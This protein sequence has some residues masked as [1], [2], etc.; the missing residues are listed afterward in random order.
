[1]KKKTKAQLEQERKEKFNYLKDQLMSSSLSKETK[2]SYVLEQEGLNSEDK[3]RLVEVAQSNAQI[4][5]LTKAK[6]RQKGVKVLPIMFNETR[7]I[8]ELH[9]ALTETGENV[10]EIAKDGKI[11]VDDL[12][13]LIKDVNMYREAIEISEGVTLKDQFRTIS[14]E[15]IVSIIEKNESEC[16]IA[17]PFI[18]LSVTSLARTILMALYTAF[19]A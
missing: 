13:E 14:F 8:R 3:L 15:Q 18:K 4:T 2:V 16:N 1:M 9:L 17:D 11:G 19:R 7:D 6:N 10:Y 12:L 5:A